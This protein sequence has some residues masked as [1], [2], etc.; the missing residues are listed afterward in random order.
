MKPLATLD[1]AE[2]ERMAWAKWFEMAPLLDRMNERTNDASEFPVHPHSSLAGDDARLNPYQ[3]SHA[4]RHCLNAG[5][6]HLH[7]ASVLVLG[8]GD[9]R[10]SGDERHHEVLL[11]MAAH[12]SLARAALEALA[13]AFWMLHP[14]KRA[15]RVE[16]T[17]R[18]QAQNILDQHRA[19]DPLALGGPSQDEKWQR[20]AEIHERTLGSPMP[21]RFKRGY[22]STETVSYVTEHQNN[23]LD[24]KFAWQLCSGFAHGRP[25]AYLGALQREQADTDEPDVVQLRLSSSASSALYGPLAAMHLL[26]DLLRLHQARSAGR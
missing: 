17:I 26:Q 9:H 20:L 11:H 23:G 1:D 25:W 16:R 6:D 21:A 10:S 7:A 19:V 14:R 3:L 13:A 15:D 24:T 22:T 8:R 12:A 5:V 2:L 4:L 18:W